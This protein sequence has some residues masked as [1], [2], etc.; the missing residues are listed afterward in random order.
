MLV[1]PA[2]E[3]FLDRIGP[4]PREVVAV[5][6]PVCGV[7]RPELGQ[8]AAADDHEWDQRRQRDGRQRQGAIEPGDSLE[9][10]DGTY[11]KAGRSQNVRVRIARSRSKPRPPS[12][13]RPSG[14][15]TTRA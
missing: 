3:E 14:L 13:D 2:D 1:P 9:A 11:T 6:D 12:L 5:D 7:V 15:A 8:N 10:V 4:F